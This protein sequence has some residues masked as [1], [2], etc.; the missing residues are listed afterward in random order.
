MN[1]YI[2][3]KILLLKVSCIYNLMP[4]AN[5]ELSSC[6]NFDCT[7]IKEIILPEIVDMCTSDL[8]VFVKGIDGKKIMVFLTTS[9]GLK[10]NTDQI[11]CSN[12]IDTFI[13][14][15]FEIK[16]FQK[17]II[18]KTSAST[19][20][21]SSTA[22]TTTTTMI[23][24]TKMSTASVESSLLDAGNTTVTSQHVKYS[25][26]GAHKFQ[27]NKSWEYLYN[28]FID[29]NDY[30]KMIR[31]AFEFIICLSV[32]FY[33]MY[34]SK[35]FPGALKKIKLNFKKNKKNRSSE[36]NNA[37]SAM[38][39]IQEISPQ[40]MKNIPKEVIINVEDLNTILCQPSEIASNKISCGCT[41]GCVRGCRCKNEKSK[42]SKNCRCF[43][44]DC[45]NQ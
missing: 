19:S 37:S 3:I 13:L 42:C 20:T 17:K 25:D 24:T 26:A 8:P 4:N 43:E 12:K 29:D 1:L 36:K 22:L 10:F 40:Y 34:L 11:E 7:N 6:L 35:D 28:K 44:M 9:G 27:N 21:T 41:K 32:F 45:K 23:R 16:R 30:V 15:N 18:F 5:M 39:I 33:C 14:K 2:L 38:S 31:D